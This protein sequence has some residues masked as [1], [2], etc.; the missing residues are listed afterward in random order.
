M[1]QLR[2]DD[3][4]RG[5]MVGDFEP[6][7]YRTTACEV[8]CQRYEAGDTE[9]LHVH[10]VATEITLIASGRARMNGRVLG[11]GDILRLE[12]GD[13]AD[14]V[15]LEPTISVVVKLPSVPGDKY[16]IEP[17]MPALKAQTP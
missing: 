8:A 6:A 10:R 16:V 14:F 5:W 4:I 17:A 1:T 9:P 12:P 7:C 3:M 11:P 15:A 2:L 13:A